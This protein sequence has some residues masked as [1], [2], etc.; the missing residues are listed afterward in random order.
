MLTIID[1]CVKNGPHRGPPFISP[2]NRLRRL[3]LHPRLL[4]MIDLDVKVIE[5]SSELTFRSPDLEL[6]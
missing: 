2:F 3:F 4:R 1:W 6:S 5:T